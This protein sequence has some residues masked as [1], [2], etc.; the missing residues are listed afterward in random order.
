MLMC[1]RCKSLLIVVLGAA[2]SDSTSPRSMG[3]SELEM[4]IVGVLSSFDIA[5]MKE[6]DKDHLC[7]MSVST[8]FCTALDALIA[9]VGDHVS[10]MPVEV[11]IQ[12]VE[13]LLVGD[14]VAHY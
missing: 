7:R 1:L 3:D 5:M 11:E 14:Q 9:Q 10:S 6:F 4:P 2:E 8:F 13:R 12:K